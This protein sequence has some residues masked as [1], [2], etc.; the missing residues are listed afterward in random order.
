MKKSDSFIML[1][2]A[3]LSVVSSVSVRAQRRVTP[4]DNPELKSVV[5]TRTTSPTDSAGIS[6]PDGVVEQTDTEGRIILVDTVTGHEYTDTILLRSPKRI[7]PTFYA[8]SVGVNVWDAAARAFGADYGLGSVWAEMSFHNWLNP[9]IEVGLGS[10]DH[11]P[12]DES[13]RYKSSVAP[14]FKIGMNY[15]FL[16]NSNPHYSVYAGVRLGFSSF[17]Y[18]IEDGSTS[19]GYW[20]MT[21]PVNVPRQSTSAVYA[22]GLAG[23]RV[24]IFSDIYLGWEIKFHTLLSD[25]AMPYGKPW[26][27]PGYGTRG[28]TF[29]ASFSI[30]YQIPLHKK[31]AAE[32]L[33]GA[34]PQ[35]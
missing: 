20:D 25:K 6:R 19:S 1:I 4:I 10:A 29:A 9:Y 27:I 13:F 34:D 31:K 30:S 18:R 2:V 22:E 7:Y 26:Y 24:Y 15:N 21:E 32:T 28:S 8:V 5:A 35:P 14:F 17:S 12:R 23:V 3:L 16:Y 33:P 11:T